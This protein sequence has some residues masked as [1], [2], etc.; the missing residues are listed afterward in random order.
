VYGIGNH[1]I[2]EK[3]KTTVFEFKAFIRFSEFGSFNV[4]L[5]VLTNTRISSTGSTVLI[6]KPLIFVGFHCVS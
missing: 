3:G 6:E 1:Q 5:L 4:D 2:L